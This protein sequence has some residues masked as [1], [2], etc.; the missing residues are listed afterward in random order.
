M[1]LI[2]YDAQVSVGSNLEAVTIVMLLQLYLYYPV[3][4]RARNKHE[5]L[6]IMCMKKQ[7]WFVGSRAPGSDLR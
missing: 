7:S 1:E 3:S 5:A 6:D 2:T 4:L